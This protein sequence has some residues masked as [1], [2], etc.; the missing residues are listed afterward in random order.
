MHAF[1][2][3]SRSV[4]LLYFPL[5]LFFFFLS[6]SSY[7]FFWNSRTRTMVCSSFYDFHLLHGLPRFVIHLSPY[8]HPSPSVPS[9]L[10]SSLVC[11]FSFC[12]L[13]KALLIFCSIHHSWLHPVT[14]IR[15][16]ILGI[17]F[18]LFQFLQ[19]SSCLGKKEQKSVCFPKFRTFLWFHVFFLRRQE[20]YPEQN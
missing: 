1:T 13:L 11:I 19:M 12:D 2:N 15:Q 9:T 7:C 6:S 20:N 16:Q 18:P 14:H 3:E 17:V 8:Q 5:L 4:R 10:A